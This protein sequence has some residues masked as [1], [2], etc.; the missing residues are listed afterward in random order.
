M[1]STK[2]KYTTKLEQTHLLMM[3]RASSKQAI[4]FL[5]FALN[6]LLSVSFKETFEFESKGNFV[7]NQDD[8][9]TELIQISLF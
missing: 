1:V 8:C 6:K 3:L 5:Y 9:C 4:L 2:Q 7:L